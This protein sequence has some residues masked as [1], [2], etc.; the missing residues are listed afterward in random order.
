MGGISAEGCQAGETV[1]AGGRQDIKPD[2]EIQKHK[3]DCQAMPG[4]IV[5]GMPALQADHS[6]GADNRMEQAHPDQPP[7]KWW[8]DW[9]KPGEQAHWCRGG[10]FYLTYT[11]KHFVKYKGQQVKTCLKYN[12]SVFQ[13]GYI[14]CGLVDTLGCEKCYEEFEKKG[15]GNGR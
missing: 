6:P 15:E 8:S 3:K 11:C 7:R 10:T 9:N 12:V 14:E 1:S 13:D 2:A 4:R 5:P